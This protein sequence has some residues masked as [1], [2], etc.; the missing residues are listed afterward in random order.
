MTRLLGS[1]LNA[2]RA[3]ARLRTERRT[4][5]AATMRLQNMPHVLL[6]DIAMSRGEINHCVRYG[7]SCDTLAEDE[8][9][10]DDRVIAA[11]LQKKS[12]N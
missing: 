1:V 7:R 2:I 11:A 4:V 5:R 8:Q 6:K 9:G 12:E 10:S 3:L